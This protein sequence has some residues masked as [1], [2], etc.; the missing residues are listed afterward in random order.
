MFFRLTVAAF[1]MAAAVAQAQLATPDPDWKE[2]EAPP[3]PALHL[4]KLIPIEIPG[5]TLRY[6]VDPASVS[7]GADGVVRYVVVAR[8]STGAV[9]AMYEGIRCNTAEVKVYARHNPDSGW[10]RNTSGEWGPLHETRPFR[11]S[12]AIAR[13]GAC[14][15]HGANR[16]AEHIVRDLRSPSG[17]R[18]E[19]DS[20]R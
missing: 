13:T 18:F 17:N 15:G 19:N 12:L 14:M 3:P 1:A 2:A 10:S 11:H 20:R 9:N 7:L 5:A 6:G 16:S 4:D 8:S